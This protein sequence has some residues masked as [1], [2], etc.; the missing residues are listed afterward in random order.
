LA[1][2][3][4]A[5]I[6]DRTAIAA[7]FEVDGTLV[8]SNYLHAITWRQAFAQAGHDV[9]IAAIHHAIGMGSNQLLDALLPGGRD[10]EADPGIRTAHGALAQTGPPPR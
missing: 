2:Q 6:Y 3:R 4:V 1:G 9:P 8:D 10:K 7:L 5:G